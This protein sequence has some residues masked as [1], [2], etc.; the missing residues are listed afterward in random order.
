MSTTSAQTR[1]PGR[2][3]T[4]VAVEPQARQSEPAVARQFVTFSFYR[5]TEAF[6]ALAGEQR[7]GVARELVD[8][9]R[10]WEQRCETRQDVIVKSYS[11]AGLRAEIDFMIW[12]ISEDPGLLQQFS[13]E[14]HSADLRRYVLCARRYL[15]QTKRSQYVVKLDP[16][17][18][19]AESRFRIV[20]GNRKYIFVYPFVKTRDWY[21]LSKRAR[22]GIMDE[23]I[24]VGTRYRSV[25]LN[26]TY[27]FGLDDQEFVVAF[28][29]DNPSDFLDLVQEL[30]ET[31]SSR[32]TLRDTPIYTCV[33]LPMD[34]IVTQFGA[35]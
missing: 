19:E 21:L 13:A 35:A 31:E 12:L 3:P 17:H 8:L 23:H 26:T 4:A 15:S 9:V 20:P 27:S 25:K 34:Q 29:T 6:H 7:A 24:E 10:R 33:R 22:Q 16:E 2:P 28:E 5:F 11:L 30:R 14:L 32:Y 1:P 18:S